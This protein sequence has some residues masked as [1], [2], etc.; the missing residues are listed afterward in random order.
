ML[1]RQARTTLAR[2]QGFEVW[3]LADRYENICK[4]RTQTTPK[5]KAIKIF[6]QKRRSGLKK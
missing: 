1:L 6:P 5:S 2:P 4:P 3:H